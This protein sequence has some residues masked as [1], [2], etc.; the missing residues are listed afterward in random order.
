MA[1]RTWKSD[2]V[3]RGDGACEFCFEEWPCA[4]QRGVKRTS[5][6]QEWAEEERKEAEAKRAAETEA[7]NEVVRAALDRLGIDRNKVRLNTYGSS[8]YMDLDVLVAMATVINESDRAK[9]GVA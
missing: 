7:K 1:R 5:G 2:H 6:I 3:D 8:I 4:V 9:E